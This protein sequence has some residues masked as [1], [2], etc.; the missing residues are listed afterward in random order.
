MRFKHS[1]PNRTGIALLEVLVAATLLATVGAAWTS[2]AWQATRSAE[3][4]ADREREMRRASA[5][6]QAMTLLSGDDLAR[7]AG[8]SRVD[9]LEVN[10]ISVDQKLLSVTVTDTLVGA[11]ILRTKLYPARRSSHVR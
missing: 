2:F 4:L 11:V 3:L 6:L 8:V 5:V 10:I 9:G 7:R 1:R